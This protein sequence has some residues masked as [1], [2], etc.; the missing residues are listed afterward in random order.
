MHRCAGAA[1]RGC[2]PGGRGERVSSS[3][4]CGGEGLSGDC[5][6]D[7]DEQ[8]GATPTYIAALN[9]HVECIDALVR[10]G[11]DVNKAKQVSASALH[12]GAEAR[13]SAATVCVMWM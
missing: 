8:N 12:A 13:A 9:G 1:W 4:W 11:A 7:V 6:R 5:V 3:W 10:H 2:E